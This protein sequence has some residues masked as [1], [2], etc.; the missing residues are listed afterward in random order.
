MK[1]QRHISYFKHAHAWRI[2]WLE[3]VEAEQPEEIASKGCEN[4]TGLRF[5]PHVSPDKTEN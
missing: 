4:R 3:L 5:V 1:Q 2:A